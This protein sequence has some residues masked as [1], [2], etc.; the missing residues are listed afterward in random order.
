M[1]NKLSESLVLF[2]EMRSPAF[3]NNCS[4][5]KDVAGMQNIFLQHWD[6]VP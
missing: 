2:F 3:K 4:E 1:K 6:M 5:G